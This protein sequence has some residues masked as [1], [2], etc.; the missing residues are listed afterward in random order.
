M[1]RQQS[2]VRYPIES[3]P[4]QSP[5]FAL[6]DRVHTLDDGSIGIVEFVRTDGWCCLRWATGRREWI[7]ESELCGPLTC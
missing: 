2:Q 7:L 5:R 3:I 6:G 4:E 1:G